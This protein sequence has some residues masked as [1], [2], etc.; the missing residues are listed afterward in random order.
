MNDRIDERRYNENNTELSVVIGFGRK[1][2]KA[3]DCLNALIQAQMFESSEHLT[4]F[5]ELLDCYGEYPFFSKGLC[6]CMYLSAWDEEH[7]AVM[8][9]TLNDM[10]LGREEN[11]DDMRF[12]GEL[13]AEEH[14]DG[15]YY[16]YHLSC[17]FLDDR[18]FLESEYR[19]VTPEYRYIIE[20]GLKAAAII[21]RVYDAAGQGEIL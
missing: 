2:M 1:S 17:A 21:E 9:Q 15:E 11:T 8:L 10:A 7:F 16:M 14:I 19:Y 6:K 13:L 5:Q 18:P 20:K 4:R 3:E 12:Q